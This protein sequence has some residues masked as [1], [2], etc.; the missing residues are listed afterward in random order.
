M[1][2]N[3]GYFRRP[4]RAL[5]PVGSLRSVISSKTVILANLHMNSG[6]FTPH[7]HPSRPFVA[8]SQSYNIHISYENKDQLKV[9]IGKIATMNHSFLVEVQLQLRDEMDLHSYVA[10][11]TPET[12]FLVYS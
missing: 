7:V 12:D 11:L 3:E 6:W 9:R 4:S 2:L 8:R 10:A 1:V 5:I